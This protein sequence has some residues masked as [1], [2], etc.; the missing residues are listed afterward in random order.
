MGG[1]GSRCRR[2]TTALAALL[3]AALCS[4]AVGSNGGVA[5]GPRLDPRHLP[6][7]A[8]QGIALEQAGRL[9]LVGLDGK[10]VGHVPGFRLAYAPYE[11][12]DLVTA[13]DG[14]GTSWLLEPAA[15]RFRESAGHIPLASGAEFVP[16]GAA[17]RIVSGGKTVWSF[18]KGDFF[19]ISQGRDLVTDLGR[20][21]S[22]VFDLRTGAVHPIPRG[23]EAASRRGSS[24]VLLCAA[25]STPHRPGTLEELA[26][27]GA[28]I[29]LARRPPG[30]SVGFWLWAYVSP[31]RR[32]IAAE[33]SG[34]CESGTAYFLRG[35]T[36]RPA[37][38]GADAPESAF[39]GWSIDGAAIVSTPQGGCGHTLRAGVY[40]V[41]P[42]TERRRL[43]IGT[44]SSETGTAL[45]TSA[46]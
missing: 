42:S 26:P 44:G 16:F 23:C 10:V 13:E 38:P 20:V 28:R 21:H 8:A 11:L 19:Y 32:T 3:A 2:V 39:L 18:P 15:R 1:V 33:W 31:D 9:V 37:V 7:L 30:Q 34:E 40:R 29:V 43:V 4:A 35:R 46:R 22:R 36:L 14:A 6:L 45:W 27:S 5:P 41:S 17:R 25:A 24:L 12:P